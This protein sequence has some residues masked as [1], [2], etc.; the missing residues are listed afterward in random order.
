MQTMNVRT[1]VLFLV[2]PLCWAGLAGHAWPAATAEGDVLHFKPQR[3][4]AKVTRVFD[5]DTV[6]VSPQE[7]GPPRKL[8]LLGLDAPEIC[9]S[10]GEA[11][12]DALAARVLHQVVQVEVTRLDDY[13]RGL[14]RLVFSGGDVGAWLVRQGHAWSYRWRASL[15]PYAEEESLARQSRRGLF[16]DQKA[17]VPRTFRQRHGPCTWPTVQ[18]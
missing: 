11:S 1:L 4:A 16:A 18:P 6:W 2:V 9:Q 3:Y 17:E 10:G 15:G 13:G 7:G 5:G 12:R 14:A 8:R